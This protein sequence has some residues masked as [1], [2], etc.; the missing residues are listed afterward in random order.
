[1]VYPKRNHG[2]TEGRPHFLSYGGG[3][4][5]S[6]EWFQKITFWGNWL[7]GTF[8]NKKM[9]LVC[10]CMD[11][12]TNHPVTVNSWI[13][14]KN[15]SKGLEKTSD[16]HLR[17][18]LTTSGAKERRLSPRWNIGVR[19]ACLCESCG[20]FPQNGDST[21]YPSRGQRHGQFRRNHD[22]D[23]WGFP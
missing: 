3:H 5:S 9:S 13:A 16:N 4:G 11:I 14:K 19:E 23:I 8:A 15:E 1:M 6:S 18:H 21:W 22:D 7:K 10:F 2:L 20:T 17:S 12:P